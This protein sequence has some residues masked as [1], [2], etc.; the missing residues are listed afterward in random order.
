MLDLSN[1]TLG[2]VSGALLFIAAFIG[3]VIA[4]VKYFKK[5][6]ELSSSDLIQRTFNEVKT[7]IKDT[8]NED[9]TDITDEL[10]E[11]AVSFERLADN[12]NIQ[13]ATLLALAADRI[14]QAYNYYYNTADKTIDP[15]A[16]DVLDHLY[17]SYK[18]LGGNGLVKKQM[19]YIKSLELK[20]EIK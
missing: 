3:V 14:Q 2:Q 13:Q 12:D 11:L 8:W 4:L 6:V 1:I 10:R 18:E 9:L 19:A 5:A 20:E 17:Q 15:R 16:Y 7:E